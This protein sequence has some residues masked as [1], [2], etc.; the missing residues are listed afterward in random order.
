MHLRKLY[1]Y[2]IRGIMHDWLKSTHL[3]NRAQFTQIENYDPMPTLR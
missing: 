3:T 1:A 2:D